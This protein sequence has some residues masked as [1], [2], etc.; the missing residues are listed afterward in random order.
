M[1]RSDALHLITNGTRG[2]KAINYTVK[3]PAPDHYRQTRL[4][5]EYLCGLNGKSQTAAPNRPAVSVSWFNTVAICKTNFIRP[6]L[7]VYAQCFEI[8]TR[9]KN[10]SRNGE[11]S[12]RVNSKLRGAD[13]GG[14]INVHNARVAFY[15][16]CFC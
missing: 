9:S 4:P 5:S 1:W 2:N 11:H 15:V 6:K 13:G 10:R 12:N 7:R 16:K 8:N 14:D 3:T